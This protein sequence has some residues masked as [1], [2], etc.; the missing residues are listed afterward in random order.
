MKKLLLLTFA[1]CLFSFNKT[2]AQ[3]SEGDFYISATGG[4]F[5]YLTEG[6]NKANP[7]KERLIF[8]I[9]GNYFVSNGISITGGID[10]FS[11]GNGWT[12]VAF[13]TRMYPGAGSFYFR[14]KAMV[15]T[16]NRTQND[17]LIGIGNDFPVSDSFAA[18]INLDYQFVSNAIGIKGGFALTF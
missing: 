4:P 10:Y 6:Q 13:G 16:K 15:S 17:F 18:E 7:L 1:L 2:Q 11:A 5:F 9:E 12:A 8:G 3:A 14:H